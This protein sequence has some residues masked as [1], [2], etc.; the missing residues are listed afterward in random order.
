MGFFQILNMSNEN[1]GFHII[2]LQRGYFET[3]IY[4]QD[5]NG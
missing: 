1:V 4:F 2:I 5:N 3:Y